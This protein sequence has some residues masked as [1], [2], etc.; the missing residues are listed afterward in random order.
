[1]TPAQHCRTCGAEIVWCIAEKSGK[2]IPVDV[3]HAPNGNLVLLSGG[4]VKYAKHGEEGVR[5]IS[6]FA[7]CPDAEGWRSP[8]ETP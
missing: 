1:M 6:H 8:K 4:R 2:R 5:Y 7:T 3:E